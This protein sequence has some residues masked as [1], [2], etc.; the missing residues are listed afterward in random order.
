MK[1]IT[2]TDRDGW[3]RRSVVRDN[4]TEAEAEFGIPAGP[5]DVRMFDWDAIMRDINNSLVDA[6]LFDWMD[7]Q[8]SQN[9]L[10]IA[11]SVI[12]RHLI[13]AYRNEYDEQ[14]KLEKQNNDTGGLL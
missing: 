12:K 9:G 4:D 2:W 3:K 5:P 10:N 11:T 6:G 14:K 13:V 1:T 8:R 7:V